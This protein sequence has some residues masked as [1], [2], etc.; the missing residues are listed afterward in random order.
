M[1]SCPL[2]NQAVHKWIPTAGY[3]CRRTQGLAIRQGS[4]FHVAGRTSGLLPPVYSVLQ[5][6]EGSVWL[7]LAGRG[8][9]KWL[10]YREWESFTALSGLT[11]ETVYEILPM[12]GGPV[13]VGTESGFFRGDRHDGVWVW[14]LEKSVGEIPCMRSR[15]GQRALFGWVRMCAGWADSIRS[16]IR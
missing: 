16:A 14:N 10:G 1:R 7:G 8:L 4:R 5:D 15:R 11:G 2:P 6:R 9:A 13:W 12:P 3:W